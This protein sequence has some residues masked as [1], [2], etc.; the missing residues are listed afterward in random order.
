MLGFRLKKL[1]K[2]CI[3]S[4]FQAVAYT[5]DDKSTEW[6]A[7]MAGPSHFTPELVDDEFV[8]GEIIMAEPL[9]ACEDSLKNTEQVRGKILVAERGDCTFVSKARLAQKSGAL[10][11]IVCDNVPGSSGETQP[12]FA[13]SGDGNNDVKIPVVFMYS[14]E[15]TKLSSVMQRKPHLKV[16]LMQ[17][18]EFKRWQLA[19]ETKANET[20]TEQTKTTTTA[21][22][23]T[24]AKKTKPDKEL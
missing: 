16:R 7:L 14:Q 8:E 24:P 10:A 21:T 12:M 23:T 11:L 5:V 6:T 22:T 1:T 4:H 3:L 13:M 17:M 19:K 20:T 9:R 2:S 15:F 18:I